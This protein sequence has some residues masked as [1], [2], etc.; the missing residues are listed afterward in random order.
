MP[1]RWSIVM[2]LQTLDDAGNVTA[3]EPLYDDVSRTYP[4]AQEQA[5]RGKAT[6]IKTESGKQK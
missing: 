6:K 4:D 2:T 3:E 1:K 5:V